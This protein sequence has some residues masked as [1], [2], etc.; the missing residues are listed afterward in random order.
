MRRLRCISV[1]L[2]AVSAFV[3]LTVVGSPAAYADGYGCYT[4]DIYVRGGEAHYTECKSPDRD[5][6]VDGWVKDTRADGK[7][8][9]V[10]GYWA[11]Q[12]YPFESPRACPK[13][14]VKEFH[15]L[16]G[17]FDDALVYLRTVG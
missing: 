10:Y 2:V 16:G 4:H 11:P 12:Y 13:G 8:A 3:S 17:G 15:H 14:T 9:Q 1:V 7:C 6:Y 5:I